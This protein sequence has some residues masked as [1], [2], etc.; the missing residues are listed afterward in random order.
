MKTG[1]FAYFLWEFDP[2]EV[3]EVFATKLVIKFTKFYCMTDS[4]RRLNRNDVMK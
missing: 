3:I 1:L 4:S 2:A